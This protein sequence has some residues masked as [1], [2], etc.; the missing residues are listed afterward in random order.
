MY[1]ICKVLN[2]NG[3]IA[4]DMNDSKEYVLL[5]KG[6]GFGKKVGERFEQPADCTVYSLQETTSR[7]EPSELI[8]S[9]QPEYF[10]IANQILNEAERQFGKIDRSILFPMADHIAFAV[11]RLQKGEQISNPLT[12]D[13]KTLFHSEF[14]VASRIRPILREEKGIEIDDDEVGYVALHIHSAL[15]KE[16]VSVSMQMAQAVRDCVSLIEDQRGIRINVMSLSY[17]RLMNHVKYMVARVLKG[18][19]LK[20]NMNDYVQHNFPES[21]E[22][23]TTVC[24]HLS[25][26]LHK[27]LEELEVGY[28]AMHIERV[29][30]DDES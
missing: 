25:H 26:A 13:I 22:L 1:R 28:L 27:Q 29:S 19:S 6:V 2:H 18:E 3:V 9:I 14:K 21:Y 23:A 17:N 7:G 4:L 30:Q 8:K 5:G 15:E 16:S 10:Q 12:E 24:D 11:Q 20:V